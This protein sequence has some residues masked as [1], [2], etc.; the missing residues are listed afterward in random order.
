VRR[1]EPVGLPFDVVGVK[2]GRGRLLRAVDRLAL[3]LWP[4]MF[5]YQFIL[6]AEPESADH[7][8]EHRAVEGQGEGRDAALRPSARQ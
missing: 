8:G 3:S 5:G 7:R 4:T 6:E 1:L 2:A